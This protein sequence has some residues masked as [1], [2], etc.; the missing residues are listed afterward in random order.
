M[1]SSFLAPQGRRY[2]VDPGVLD[3][4]ASLAFTNGH[5]HSL[6]LA[7]HRETGGEML[8]FAK[9][10]TP[11]DHV[12]VRAVDGRLIDIGGARTTADVVAQGG[13][14]LGVDEGT[15]YSL[16][17]VYQWAT[18]EPNAARAWVKP[19]LDH[20]KAN[21]AHRRIACFTHT[22]DLDE[23][24]TIHIEWTE[25]D[26]ALRLIAF[27]RARTDAVTWTRCLS[28]RVPENSFGERVIDFT[29]P[30]FGEHAQQFEAMIRQSRG[31]VIANLKSPPEADAPVCPPL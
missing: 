24:W 8:S 20:V 2:I 22:F 31:Q 23:E 16:P 5:C 10:E 25:A 7:L 3:D 30:A 11:F 15:L 29:L 21:E 26:G 19:V 28:C 14:L 1:T 6:A 4:R 18:P 13:Q 9:H 17:H 12:L 27:G